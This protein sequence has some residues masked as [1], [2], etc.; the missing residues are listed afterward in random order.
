VLLVSDGDPALLKAMGLDGVIL[1]C[2]PGVQGEEL[3]T[4]I[5]AENV[6]HFGRLAQE[7]RDHGMVCESIYPDWNL[8]EKTIDDPDYLAT[9]KSLFDGLARHG[10]T[11]LLISC[12]LRDLDALSEDHRNAYEHRF[13]T[14]LAELYEHA[15]SLGLRLCLHTSLMPWIYLND[16]DAWDHWFQRFPTQ[17]NCIVLCLGCAE[18]AGLDALR[19]VEKWHRR[20]RAVHVRNVEGRFHDSSHK[21]V[22]LDHGKLALPRA[23]ESLARVDFQGAIIPEHFPEFPCT[24][25]LL[26]SRAFALGYCRALIQAYRDGSCEEERLR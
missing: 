26:V 3:G 7:A 19:L 17:A 25:G 4:V 21:D 15:E 18:S 24:D 2:A 1:G 22:R 6:D 5:T 13:A 23:F 10:L 14:H 9:V 20:I 11:D 8:V 16:I 12:G